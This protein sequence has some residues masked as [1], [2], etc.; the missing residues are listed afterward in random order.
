MEDE[1]E[2]IPQQGLLVLLLLLLLLLVSFR[3]RTPFFLFL[4]FRSLI[5]QDVSSQKINF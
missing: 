1:K 5:N 4:D 2:Q 3:T